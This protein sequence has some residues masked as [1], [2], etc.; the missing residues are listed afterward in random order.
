MKKKITIPFLLALFLMLIIFTSQL[1]AQQEISKVKDKYVIRTFK[2]KGKTIQ[3][4]LIPGPPERP[5][6]YN[7][8][9]VELPEPDPAQ[10]SG[11]HE[12]PGLLDALELS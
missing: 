11:R 3:E 6:G 5:I 8:S 7:P 1:L 9:A 10:R 2:F 12:V 4:V